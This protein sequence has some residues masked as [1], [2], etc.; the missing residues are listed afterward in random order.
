MPRNAPA[1]ISAISPVSRFR[2]MIAFGRARPIRYVRRGVTGWDKWAV[3][4][5][6]VNAL[7][8]PCGWYCCCVCC[9]R[10]VC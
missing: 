8:L 4:E 9:W 5:S 10:E 2:P 6:V 1:M 7:H 3:W